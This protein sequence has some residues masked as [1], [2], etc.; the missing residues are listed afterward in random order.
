MDKS[1]CIGVIGDLHM[2]ESLGYADYVSDRRI[3]EKA[4]ILGFI[5]EK[6]KDCNK[7]VLLGDNFNG[8]NNHSEVIREFV[9]FLERLGD[10]DI[11]ILSGNHERFGDGKTAIDFLKE[12]DK[13]NWHIFTEI[14]TV[15]DKMGRKLTFC[16][17]YNRSELGADDD[18]EAQKIIM[19]RLE[20]D[21][22]ILFVHHAISDS[23]TMTGLST[24]VFSEIILPKKELQ[25]RYQMIF[26]GHI[27]LP[28]EMGSVKIAGSIFNNEM[29]ETEKFIWKIEDDM[30]VEKIRLPGR[31]IYKLENPD[32][33]KL[34]KINKDNIVKVILTEKM[35]DEPLKKLREILRDSF[36]AYILVEQY[37]RERK[38][39]KTN[40]DIIDFNI[41]GLLELYAKNKGIDII[42]LKTAWESIRE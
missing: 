22:H 41:D 28:Q 2:K 30:S 23:K 5:I 12:I 24:N 26:G 33:S 6:L 15:L 1:G 13:P 39:D 11:Y 40:G 34:G 29:G 25:K 3:P 21:G 10:K 27:H 4:Q 17:Y 8:R 37:A 14:T 36:D 42:K 9:A 7:I 20:Q 31:G 38:Q 19:N 18:L 35:E 16:P 32:V